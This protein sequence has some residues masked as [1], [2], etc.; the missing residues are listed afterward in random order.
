MYG[1]YDQ[2][3]SR[4]KKFSQVMAEMVNYP[5]P[6]GG[7][8]RGGVG[9]LPRIKKM[10]EPEMPRYGKTSPPNLLTPL[11]LLNRDKKLNRTD[12]KPVLSIRRKKLKRS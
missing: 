8:G 7:G 11:Y 9:C 1:Y 5:C 12:K 2:S 6:Q 10:V 3:T 4:K